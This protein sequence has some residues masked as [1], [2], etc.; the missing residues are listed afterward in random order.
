VDGDREQ[1]GT[2]VPTTRYM[3]CKCL[4]DSHVPPN[5]FC[6]VHG[7]PSIAAPSGQGVGEDYR[8]ALVTVMAHTGRCGM[9]GHTH[10]LSLANGLLDSIARI[11]NAALAT[12]P[13]PQEDTRDAKLW[14]WFRDRAWVG[15]TE[16]SEIFLS[17]LVG[18][19]A[20]VECLTDAERELF[21]NDSPDAKDMSSLCQRIAE[22]HADVPAALPSNPSGEEK[23]DAT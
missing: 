3:E 17:T 21:E 12:P 5:P 23:Y 9:D 14:R 7:R 11:V 1:E 16:D 19:P 20:D 13:A 15:T 18:E 4:P 22:W 6:E 10:D 2:V 8:S